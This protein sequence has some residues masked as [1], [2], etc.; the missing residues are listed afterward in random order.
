MT[1][2]PGQHTGDLTCP[3]VMIYNLSIPTKLCLHC[4][5]IYIIL[6]FIFLFSEGSVGFIYLFLFI[7]PL[8]WLVMAQFMKSSFTL[9]FVLWYVEIKHYPLLLN[10]SVLARALLFFS[11]ANI[12]ISPL[13]SA[14]A[15]C[16]RA[17][18]DFTHAETG[19]LQSSETFPPLSSQLVYWPLHAFGQSIC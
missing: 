11:L 8:T 14:L 5:T 6:F 16:Q 7:D 4:V 3:I 9:R 1:F 10:C 15:C 19:G 17:S 13:R 18:R 2:Q 12:K